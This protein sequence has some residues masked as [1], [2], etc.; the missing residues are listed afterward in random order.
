MQVLRDL[1]SINQGNDSE[2]SPCV[3]ELLKL[4]SKI[5]KRTIIS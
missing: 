3:H 1:V 2:M 4:T 5:R